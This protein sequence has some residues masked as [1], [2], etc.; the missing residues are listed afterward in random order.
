VS[1]EQW[2]KLVEDASNGQRVIGLFLLKDPDGEVTADNL[3]QVGSAVAVVRLLRLPDG[4]A[5]VLLQGV[6]RIE[7]QEQIEGEGYPRAKVRQLVEHEDRTTE[8]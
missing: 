8:T 2:V 7:L 1:G 3:G 6:A 4:T 5:Q